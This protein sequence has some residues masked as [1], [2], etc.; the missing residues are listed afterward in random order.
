ML[1]MLNAH[2]LFRNNVIDKRV[3]MLIEISRKITCNSY[4][5]PD[6]SIIQRISHVR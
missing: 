2:Y 6:I 1:N 4:K 3:V 5:R